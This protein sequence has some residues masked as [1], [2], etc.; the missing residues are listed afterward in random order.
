M[1][2]RLRSAVTAGVDVRAPRRP[3]DATRTS[4]PAVADADSGCGTAAR[5]RTSTP[6][7]RRERRRRA[8]SR[9]H[10]GRVAEAPGLIRRCRAVRTPGVDRPPSPGAWPAARPEDRGLAGFAVALALALLAHQLWWRGL[11]AFDRHGLVVLCAAWVLARPAAPARLALL[12]A[13]E[14][15]AIA[16]DLPSI[17][18][19]TLLAAVTSLA[20]LTAFAAAA[21]RE[22]A[23]PSAAELWRRL[24]PFLRAQAV[25]LYGAAALAKL[26]AGFL[27]PATSCAGPLTRQLAFF[28]PALLAGSTWQVGPAIA[29]TV[30][31]EAGLALGL[32]LPR[33]RRAAVVGGAG[34]HAVL[35]LA[36][37]VPFAAYALVLYVAFLP[38]GALGAL[39][40]PPWRLG[41]LLLLAGAVGAA[42]TEPEALRLALQPWLRVVT[43]AGLLAVAVAVARAAAP[44]RAAVPSGRLR[45]MGPVYALATGLLLVN[46]A[47]PYAG[48]KTEASFAM[49]SN[50]QTEPGHWNHLLVPEAVRVFGA[51]DELVRLTASTAPGLERRRRAGALMVRAELERFLRETPR[52]RASYVSVRDP[53]RRWT[54]SAATLP[55]HP[56]ADRLLNFYDVREGARGRC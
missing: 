31:A 24:A 52:A 1:P 41:A 9:R 46:A 10:R 47:S 14:V 12:A 27:D 42:T 22:R 51:Q 34:F 56:V 35:A 50:L 23:V 17:G 53:D 15:L 36:G 6:A 8:T 32:A 11:P 28:D 18:D 19:H 39:R 26:N 7:V 20:F 40:R 37:N 16:R 33:T 43:A 38:P 13:A 45:A 4:T 44:A 3:A 2:R 29:G 21:L 48:L 25:L 55:A 54:A 30:V 5:G 49:F